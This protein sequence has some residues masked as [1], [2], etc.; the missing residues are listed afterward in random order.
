MQ[1]PARKP[2]Q[3]FPAWMSGLSMLLIVTLLLMEGLP[4]QKVSG[5][6]GSAGTGNVSGSGLT[7]GA[8]ILGSGGSNIGVA[9]GFAEGVGFYGNA[10]GNGLLQ[11]NTPGVV[12]VDPYAANMAAG[13][14]GGQYITAAMTQAVAKGAGTVDARAMPNKFTLTSSWFSTTGFNGT[15]L[16]PCSTM[17]LSGSTGAG[18][19]AVPNH[20]HVVGCGWTTG[21]G[22]TAGVGSN[23][24]LCGPNTP[25]YPSS[26]DYLAYCVNGPYVPLATGDTNSDNTAALCLTNSTISPSG[27]TTGNTGGAGGIGFDSTIYG[28]DVDGNYVANAWCIANYYMEEGASMWHV[29]AHNCGGT[30]GQTMSVGVDCGGAIGGAQNSICLFDFLIADNALTGATPTAKY[31]PLR[32]NSTGGSNGNPNLIMKGSIVNN[33]SGGSDPNYDVEYASG[34]LAGMKIIGVHLESALLAGIA[35]GISTIAGTD[36]GETANGLEL[37]AV[38]CGPGFGT[39]GAACHRAFSNANLSGAAVTNF[40]LQNYRQTSTTAPQYVNLDDNNASGSLLGTTSRQEVFY[41]T[42]GSSQTVINLHGASL[43]DGSPQIS[44]KLLCTAAGDTSAAMLCTTAPTF[45]PAQ[46]DIIV[47]RT[48]VASAASA[49]LGVNGASAAAMHYSGGGVVLA[50]NTLLANE[51]YV[52]VFDGTNWS[53]QGQG[54]TVPG[55]AITGNITSAA[56][57]QG[58]GLFTAGST[59]AATTGFIDKSIGATTA[60]MGAQT[61]ATCTNITNM[62][63]PLVA[64]KNYLLRC[65]IP[66]TLATTATLQY[67]VGGPGTPTSYS[68]DVQGAN[69]ASGV[70]SDLNT[71]AQTTYGTKTTASAAAANTAVDVVTAQIQNGTTASGTNLTLQTAANGTNSITVLANAACT[72][73][74]EN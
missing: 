73:T 51:D 14:D 59:V 43:P 30:T 64:S 42:N 40:Q 65:T 47:L 18:T 24:H 48:D 9:S 29:R 49:T 12:A 58:S 66:R 67:C 44:G 41:A 3:R 17:F 72:L 46:G 27:C 37:D 38:D 22:Y 25:G 69:G 63:W 11:S 16:L 56:N 4:A 31:V 35:E 1:R 71:L 60:A 15:L 2:Y 13:T 26:G 32:I 61:T 57:V 74:Q 6:I 21:T 19:Q 55:T 36:T 39:T 28:V 53:L 10:A 54:G 33:T 34:A 5:G 45:T 7:S 20:A 50:A 52:F 8:L 68:L 70:W 23:L 62:A